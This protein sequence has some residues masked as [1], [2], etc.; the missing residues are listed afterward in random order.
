LLALDDLHWA[1]PDSLALLSFVAR[2]IAGLP[3]AVLVTLRPWPPAAC[4]LAHTL[5]HDGYAT[6]EKLAPLSEGAAAALLSARVG[7]PVE[8]SVG[9]RVWSWCAGNPLLVE[10][11]AAAIG[12][13]QDAAAL[14]AVEQLPVAESLLLARFAGLPAAG[15]RCAQAASVLGTRFRPDL[16]VT[17]ARLGEAEADL[18][19]DALHRTGLVRAQDDTF[20]EFVHPLFAQAL[21]NDLAA[22]MRARLHARAFTALTE[23]ALD[24]EAAEHA[25]RADL[26]GEMKA[27]GVLERAG[28]LALAAGALA[29]ASGHLQAAARLAGSRASSDLLL[30]L[31]EALLA[32]GRPTEAVAVYDRLLAETELVGNQ[33]VQALR[34]QGRALFAVGAHDRASARFSEAVGLAEGD[35]PSA[36]VEVLLDDA[37]VSWH[38]VGPRRSVSLVRKARDLARYADAGLCRR[39]EA[40]VGFIELL[41]GDGSGLSAAA[42]AASELEANPLVELTDLCWAFGVLVT[43]GLAA[44]FAEQFDDARRVLAPALSV[45]ERLGAV[46][47]IAGLSLSHATMFSRIGP[48]TVALEHAQRVSELAE[49]VPMFFSFA[50]CVQAK[51]LLELGRVE[52]SEVW[53]ARVE[54]RAQQAGEGLA[55]LMIGRLRAMRYLREGRLDD[56]GAALEK[57]EELSNHMEYGDPCVVQWARPAISA[58]F[59]TGQLGAVTRIIHETEQSAAR[60]PCR[61]PRIIA[62]LGRARLAEA[63]GD[64]AAAE[65]HFCSALAFHE[66]VELPIEQAH[67]LLDYGAFLRRHG[68]RL[69]ARKLLARAL[70]IAEHNQAAWIVTDVQ[71]ELAAAGGRRRRP[72]EDPTRLTAQEQRIARLAA[73]GHRNKEIAQRLTL[74]VKTIE[75]H[76]QQVYTKLGITSRRQLMLQTLPPTQHPTG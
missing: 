21:Y 74:S 67:T 53:C 11:I 65:E 10:Q 25:L 40:A 43:Y 14:A 51:V 39:A 47:A 29:T 33:R 12:R 28:R 42:A 1:D 48:L 41:A 66:H 3:V 26:T 9:R 71:A 22:S 61:Y 38:T 52:E 19:L 30:V 36:A 15:L 72:R 55:L 34:M 27:V 73:A 62:A 50:G 18:A 64:L 45:A 4:E 46:E 35:D 57:I 56:A 13:R 2:R 58:Y 76:L 70:E 44:T 16:A 60:L 5:A 69:R 54:Q 68:H 8:R 17:V 20:A 6:V 49:L 23:R 7:A 24:A 37:L 32:G 63:E 75:F 59:A 31:G